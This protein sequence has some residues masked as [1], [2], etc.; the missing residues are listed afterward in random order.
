MRVVVVE[1][2]KVEGGLILRPG[3]RIE[4]NDGVFIFL[5][6]TMLSV[7]NLNV[8]GSSIHAQLSRSTSCRI[9]YTAD[10]KDLLHSR[11]FL[12]HAD[13]ATL[14]SPRGYRSIL[15]RLYTNLM[16]TCTDH[17]A[18]RMYRNLRH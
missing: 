15:A 11:E 7:V 1:Y 10:I 3:C 13:L 18:Q 12:K 17:L 4:V 8:D 14:V 6:D 9:R 2:R 5:L 16:S